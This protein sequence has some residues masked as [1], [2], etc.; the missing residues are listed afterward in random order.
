MYNLFGYHSRIPIETLCAVLRAANKDS[1][2]HIVTGAAAGERKISISPANA[3]KASNNAR[4]LRK[5]S[6]AV[7]GQ[8]PEMHNATQQKEAKKREVVAYFVAQLYLAGALCFDRNYVAIRILESH[9]S[10]ENLLS[11]LQSKTVVNEIKA[12][13][14]SLLHSL[15]IDREPQ[16]S[17]N[18]F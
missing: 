8:V 17:L 3:R 9:Y 15:Y 1:L 4:N 10:Y 2:N 14:C 16:V 5:Q 7:K 6:V 11:V 12:P 18:N 13:V